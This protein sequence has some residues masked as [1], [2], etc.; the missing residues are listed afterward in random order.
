VG[1]YRHDPLSAAVEIA[2]ASGLTTVVAAGNDGTGVVTAPGRD[3]YVLTVGSA[4]NSLSTDPAQATV[5]AWSGSA[6]FDG[7][8]KPDVLASGVSVVSLRAPGSTIDTMYPQA[9]IDGNYFRGSGTSMSTALTSGM[10]AILIEH[11]PNATPDDVKGAITSTASPVAQT[12]GPAGE[13]NL[14]AALAAHADE[15]WNQDWK[16]ALP[17][18]RMPWQFDEWSAT[19]WSATR[20]SATRW[21]ATRWSATRWS[22]IAWDATRWSDIAWDATRWSATRWSDIAWDAT[23]WS[24][25]RWSSDSW[26]NSGP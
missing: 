5:P 9:R 4:D 8:A 6:T 16:P 12:Q 3:P 11:H 26:G 13:I 7:F 19:R 25:T 1:S 18:L 24:A 21:S 22:D 2:W 17:G 10:A 15:A 20:W 23:R 14:S